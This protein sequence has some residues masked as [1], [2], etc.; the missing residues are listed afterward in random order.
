MFLKRMFQVVIDCK[1]VE[2]FISSLLLFRAGSPVNPG[3]FSG[4]HRDLSRSEKRIQQ[5]LVFHSYGIS[6]SF[7]F[8]VHI[9]C[10]FSLGYK[11]GGKHSL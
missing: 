4:D 10:L 3:T 2:D 6:L 7:L 11:Y 8:Y 1:N 9:S 5:I